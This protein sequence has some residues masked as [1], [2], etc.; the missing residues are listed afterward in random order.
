MGDEGHGCFLLDHGG[1]DNDKRS[2]DRDEA[3]SHLYQYFIFIANATKEKT[4]KGFAP[5]LPSLSAESSSA[6][7]P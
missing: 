3:V 5:H 2:A 4:E 6:L 7:L 1:I